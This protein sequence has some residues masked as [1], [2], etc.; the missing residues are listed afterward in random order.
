[1]IGVSEGGLLETVRDGETGLLL[2]R[3]PDCQEL[4]EAVLDM[5]PDRARAM[6]LACEE[7]AQMFSSDI[8]RQRMLQIVFARS[9]ERNLAS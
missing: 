4:V 6:R 3:D 2:P 1:M 9:A 7:R 5:P 8:F